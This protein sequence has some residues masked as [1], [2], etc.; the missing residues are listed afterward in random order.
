MGTEDR[1]STTGKDALFKK[2]VSFRFAEQTLQFRVSQDLFSSHQVDFG[3][4]FLLRTLVSSEY[5][6]FRK[7][8]DLGCGYGPIGLALKKVSG[9]SF[10]HMV[11]R[12]ALAV[13]YSR[14]NA[15]LNG[16]SDVEIYGSLGYDDVRAKDFDLVTCNIPGKAGEPVI[17][18]FLR[19]AAGYLK[20]GGMVAIVVVTPLQA[21][22]EQMLTGTSGID[23]V[24]RG[25]RSGHAVFYYRFTTSRTGAEHPRISALNRGVYHRTKETFSFQGLEYT[26]QTA[27]GLPEFDSRS[28]HTELLLAGIQGLRNQSARRTVVFNPGQGHVPVVLAR[29]LNPDDIILVDRDLLSLRYSRNNL[30]LNGYPAE[31]VTLAH[32]AGIALESRKQPD[33]IVGTLRKN[34]GTEALAL[35]VGQAAGQLSSDGILMLSAGSTAVTRAEGMIRTRNQLRIQERKRWKGNSLLIARRK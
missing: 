15:G 17:S 24:F 27:R 13:E 34:E 11:D 19:D 4:S 30:V 32:Q 5:A 12:D 29:L 18:H 1:G 31:R 35:T 20:P 26:M 8:L 28:Y 6:P 25:T 14:Q 2:V 21:T 9:E 16:L 3:T 7:V 22:V 10:I 33:I 23:I